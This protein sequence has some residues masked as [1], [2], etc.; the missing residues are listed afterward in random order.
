MRLGMIAPLIAFSAGLAACTAESSGTG[1]DRSA[2]G[3]GY[4]ADYDQPP[5][6]LYGFGGPAYVAEPT[7]IGGYGAGTGWSRR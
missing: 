7:I 3:Y 6:P 1:V 2:F 4:D 5:S